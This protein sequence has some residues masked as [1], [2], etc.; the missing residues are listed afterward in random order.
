MKILDRYLGG[1][2]IGGTLLT[3]AVL[4]PLIAFFLLADEVN[5]LGEVYGFADALAVAQA[6]G[7]EVEF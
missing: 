1:A 2:V 7:I 5:D 4:L 6:K 3:M